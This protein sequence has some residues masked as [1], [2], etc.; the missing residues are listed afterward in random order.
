VK[1]AAS[2]TADFQRA[3]GQ[4]VMENLLQVHEDVQAVYAAN[5]EMI[6][7][8]LEAMEARKVDPARIV[9]VGY[10]AIPDA[11]KDLRSGRLDATVEQY[12]GKQA[13]AALRM[14]VEFIR[15][16]KRPA[17]SEVYIKPVVIDLQH[18]DEAEHK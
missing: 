11:L 1:I 12:P 10:D 7:G 18:I 3:K 13:R 2:Q 4:S 15:D 8:A 16:K 17:S 14:I 5:D 6:L 9:T